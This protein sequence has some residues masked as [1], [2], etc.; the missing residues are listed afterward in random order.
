MDPYQP[1]QEHLNTFVAALKG[2]ATGEEI[3]MD[4]ATRGT[5]G[6]PGCHGWLV[7]R[8]MNEMEGISDH[9]N[10]HFDEQRH[11]LEIF[12]ETGE[13]PTPNEI[14]ILPGAQE[15]GIEEFAADYPKWWGNADGT[16]MFVDEAAFSPSNGDPITELD[17]YNWW[18]AVAKRPMPEA[19]S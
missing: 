7:F 2:I 9:N 19:S 4:K 3:N 11:R 14:R 10:Y 17:V 8:T 15:G 16:L 12:L 1:K 5:C 18:A 13:S 6:S